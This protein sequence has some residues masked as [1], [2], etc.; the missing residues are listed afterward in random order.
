MAVGT[1][2]VEVPANDPTVPF[3]RMK[4]PAATRTCKVALGVSVVV[5]TRLPTAV[6]ASRASV[7]ALIGTSHCRSATP[8]FRRRAFKE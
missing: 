7:L 5:T 6:I 1:V 2:Q 8:G 4:V 3:A